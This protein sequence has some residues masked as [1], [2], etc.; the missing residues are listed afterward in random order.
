[1]H[2]HQNSPQR[3]AYV[4]ASLRLRQRRDR[5]PLDCY[6]QSVARAVRDEVDLLR[7]IES[8]DRDQNVNDSIPV[9]FCLTL[10]PSED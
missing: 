1:M 4:L 10:V 9:G 2:E 7:E 5:A 6:R 3:A 8:I